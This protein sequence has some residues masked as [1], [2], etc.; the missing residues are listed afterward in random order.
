MPDTRLEVRGAR[1]SN[2]RPALSELI[3]TL[4][5]GPFVLAALMLSFIV[6]A[7]NVWPTFHRISEWG[8]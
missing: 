3:L 7:F 8:D 6:V 2:P 5:A 4:F 1:S